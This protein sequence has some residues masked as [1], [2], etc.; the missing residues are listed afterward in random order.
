MTTLLSVVGRG[1]QMATERLA[2]T[3]ANVS[4]EAPG[5]LPGD[6]LAA[7]AH[8]AE[9]ARRAGRHGSVYTLLPVDPFAPLVDAWARRLQGEDHQLEVLIGV[10]ANTPVPDYYLVGGLPEPQV[11]WYLGHLRSLAPTRVA[12][13]T[14]TAPGLRET[15]ESLEYGRG[16]PDAA[17]LAASARDYVPLP[18]PEA[19]LSG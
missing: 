17:A 1:A 7:A 6:P 15:L 11:H 12:T 3:A 4:W 5:R 19:V 8:L 2:E 13:V 10:A 18:Q 16:L 14:L 9:V